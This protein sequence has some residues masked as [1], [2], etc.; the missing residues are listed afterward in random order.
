MKRHWLLLLSFALALAASG[1]TFT[2]TAGGP[3]HEVNVV[4]SFPLEVSGLTTIDSAT[5]GLVKVCFDI[6][7]T[8]V[9][10]LKVKLVA[11]DGT[12]VILSDHNGGGG[13]HYEG[14]CVA[15]DATDGP[16]QEAQAP[17]SGLY[18]PQQSINHVNNNQDPNGIWYLIVLDEVPL[19]TGEVTS[20]S[21]TFGDNPPPTHTGG[22]CSTS[23][24]N[25]CECPGG[26]N[27]CDLLPDMTNSGTYIQNHW[28]EHQGYLTEGVATPN[29]GWGPLEMH[30]T[31]ECYC[32]S[33]LVN[34]DAQ[35]LDGS[36]PKEKVLQTIYHKKGD[37]MTSYTVPAGFMT[38][39]PTHGH[40]HIDEWTYNT[41]R[42]RGS[43]PDPTTW[44]IIGTGTKNSFCLINL[45]TCTSSNEYCTDDAG[46]VVDLDSLPNGGLGSVTGCGEDQGIYVGKFDAYDQY[47]DGQEIDFGEICNGEY[48]IVSTTDPWNE[49]VEWSDSNNTSVTLIELVEQS[50]S[51]CAANFYA[52]TTYGLAPFEVQ[53]IDSTI[54]MANSWL[55]DFGDGDTST[56]QFPVHVYTAAGTYNVTLTT[57]STNGCGS[58]KVRE[59]YVEVDFGV[60]AEASLDPKSIRFGCS[61]NPFTSVAEISFYLVRPASVQLY[62]TDVAGNVVTHLIND[63]HHSGASSLKIDAG[64]EHFAAGI[65]FIHALIEGYSY[66]LKLVKI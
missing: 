41:L 31:G 28:T 63:V 34:C 25:G 8:Y 4:N 45:G 39:H 50:S 49:V 33:I 7:H 16:I 29:I 40:I 37:T 15:E 6:T 36:Y 17:Y 55:W 47:L 11:P 13:N 59:E 14:T 53:F 56:E 52:D 65:Y 2:D 58:A 30:G 66:V 24:A 35:C 60:G 10:D 51:C 54:P 32:D 62:I 46:L 12:E 48:Y 1:Q 26:A 20:W 19:D 44:P 18:Y 43:N 64:R 61:P 5:F 38:Y 3:I 27:E 23:I 42:I 22:V 9:G 57:H 21:L